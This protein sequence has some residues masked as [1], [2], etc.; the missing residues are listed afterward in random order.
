MSKTSDHEGERGQ[1]FACHPAFRVNLRAQQFQ[2]G[3]E[4]RQKKVDFGIAAKKRAEQRRVSYDFTF[5]SE[6]RDY[7]DHRN[8]GT[9]R[10]EKE[11]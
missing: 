8:G 4:K 11:I 2:R 10:K 3:K 5:F 1:I 7:S 9:W 6:S